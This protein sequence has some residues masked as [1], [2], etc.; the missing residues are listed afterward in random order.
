MIKKEM[1][2]EPVNQNIVHLNKY[3]EQLT[4]DNNNKKK[5]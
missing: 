4:S 2:R 1:G 5:T 3:L